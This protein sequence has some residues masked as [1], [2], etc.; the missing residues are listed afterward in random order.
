MQAKVIFSLGGTNPAPPSTCRGTMLK[1]V[2]AM[3]P[4]SMNWRRERLLG[5]EGL[6]FAFLF[7]SRESLIFIKT[8]EY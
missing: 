6:L 8:L 5:G 7:L 3:L 1:V 2:A 4:V